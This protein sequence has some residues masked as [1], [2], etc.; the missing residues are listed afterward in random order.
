M[1][2]SIAFII[3]LGSI[4]PFF[5]LTRPVSTM[6]DLL[7]IK[8]CFFI[9]PLQIGFNK[10]RLSSQTIFVIIDFSKDF[11]SVWRPALFHKLIS[12][13][14][15]S[16]FAHWSQSFLF[17]RCNCIVF[18]NQKVAPFEFIKVFCKDLFL[19]LCFSFF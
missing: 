17:D 19:G 3:I 11:D 9:D 15:P 2:H 7:L 16:C 13:G 5:L 6:D 18:Q 10:P 8:F 14:L 4:I 1:H 12:A